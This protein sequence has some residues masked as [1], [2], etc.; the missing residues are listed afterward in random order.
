MGIKKKLT[1]LLLIASAL[2]I[3]MFTMINL[4][5]SQNLLI[6]NAMS[7][8][9]KRTQI[10]DQKIIN[11]MDKNLSGIKLLARNP[12]IRSR[13]SE[14]I[15]PVI[16][17]ALKV[18]PELFGITLT[19]VNGQ[20]FVKT[21]DSQLANIYDRDYFQSA[22]KGNE[23]V[24]SDVLLSKTTGTLQINLASPVREGSNGNVIGVLQGTLEINMINNF[25]KE[26]STEGIT[27][28]ILDKEGK[29]LANPTQ[30]M[31]N[32]EERDD[33]NNFEFVKNGLSGKS[34]SEIVTKD[35]QKMLVSCVQD[36]KTG[37]LVCAEIPKSIAIQESLKNSIKT[38]LIVLLILVI[39]CGIIFVLSGRAIKPIQ[40]LLSAANKI[41]EGDLTVNNINI[42]SK[43]EI[44]TLGKS[45]QRMIYN[46]QEVINN[47]KEHS[48]K[49]SECSKEMIE[50]CEQQANVATDTAENTNKIAEGTFQL[51]SKIE[52]I[53]LSMENLN[54]AVSDISEKS[55]T[56]SL[57]VDN[58]S[59]YSEKG[60]DALN[61]VN[62]SMRNIQQSVN[63]TAKVIGKLGEHSK[64]ISQ[65]TEV[66]KGISE[67]TNLLAL[68]A[69]IEAARAGEQGKGFAVVAD[70]VR[71][72]AEQS[73]EAANQVSSIINGIQKETENVI[74]V[75]NK[76]IS[77]V[78]GGSKVID[79]ANNYF[80]LIFK[81]IQEISISM[82]EV[83]ESIGHM[84]NSSGD[85]FINL[86]SVIELSEKVSSE[87][88]A[89]S[90]ATEEQVASIE[91]MTASVHSFNDMV[92]NLESLTKKFKTTQDDIRN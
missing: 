24:V 53:N 15:K 17:E 23:E 35:G 55:N 48:S 66:I 25:V 41:S 89:I 54:N 37:W 83:S 21:N 59:N 79:Q 70:E 82:K 27:V 91:E 3:I 69:A 4:Y 43:D 9:L 51:S 87:T 36:E 40:L 39:T 29:M 84:N 61:G 65:I 58:A 30:S 92:V 75:M 38:S 22:V 80:E 2:P 49:V 19:D 7:D 45:F 34:N 20:Q 13:D 8:N 73:G 12:I 56:V 77:E 81:A 26:L 68:N 67:Q 57:A 71:K 14:K 6:G 62:S 76:G 46:L 64:A 78:D 63:D 28:Y 50:V 10:V 86:D 47:I 16:L 72:L 42:K 32:L 85:V 1:L 44:G 33:L 60:S 74:L 52:K 18:H 88:Q 90:A 31:D 5:F 11:L